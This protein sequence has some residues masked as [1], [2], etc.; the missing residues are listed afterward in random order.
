MITLALFSLYNIKFPKANKV[1][2]EM[3]GLYIGGQSGDSSLGLSGT[4]NSGNNISLTSFFS[5]Y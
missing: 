3:Q 5:R 2:P 1:K 4:V